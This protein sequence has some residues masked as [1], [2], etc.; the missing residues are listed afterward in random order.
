[1]RT[2]RLWL[3]LLAGFLVGGGTVFGQQG[4]VFEITG[5][6]K[7]ATDTS[8]TPVLY[9]F[10]RNGA[11]AAL[12]ALGSDSTSEP[13]EIARA[14]YELDN[15]KAPKTLTITAVNEGEVF[16]TGTTSVQITEFSD[17]SFTVKSTS[18]PMRWIRADSERY[19]VV[20]AGREG[21]Q[22]SGGPAFA[23]LIRIDRRRTE[24]ETVGLYFEGSHAKIGPVPVELRNEFMKE[25]RAASDV[26]LRIEVT[27][28]AFERGLKIMQTW[29]KRAR[30]NALL[31][32]PS[33]RSASLNNSV[34]LREIVESVNRCGETIKL[35]KLTWASDDEVAVNY[36]PPH[37]AFQYFKRLRQLNEALHIRDEKFDLLGQSV[38]PS[39]GK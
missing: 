14:V 17:G 23:M 6:W 18:G 24:V 19:F 21:A 20:L 8:S 38:N 35:Y 33:R 3:L 15:P 29:Q 31:Y 5:T 27:K 37:V 39:T 36:R 30:E 28:P 25:P 13:R 12:S 22:L 4:C 2:A 16:V 10:E 7:L 9:R 34:L 32:P 1:M 26:I 11:L